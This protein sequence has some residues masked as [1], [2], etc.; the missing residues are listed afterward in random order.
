M[1]L[2]HAT[3]THTNIC[4][5][6][7]NCA[8]FVETKWNIGFA[9]SRSA[10]KWDKLYA[11]FILAERE[12]NNKK[13]SRLIPGQAKSKYVFIIYAHTHEVSEPPKIQWQPCA[14]SKFVDLLAA[15][16]FYSYL[17]L[18]LSLSADSCQ[19]VWCLFVWINSFRAGRRIGCFIWKQK[20]IN[21]QNAII[22]SALANLFHL[23]HRRQCVSSCRLHGHRSWENLSSG[24]K[25]TRK[26]GEKCC[27]HGMEA[28]RKEKRGSTLKKRN[29]RE[30]EKWEKPMCENQNGK[31]EKSNHSNSNTLCWLVHTPR[32]GMDRFW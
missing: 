7:A 15:W 25:S 10:T 18:S 9:G 31:G 30:K 16:H 1:S 26:M 29:A 11:C 28:K 2:T 22:K 12:Q 8:R 23:I 3:H 32:N 19:R 21:A 13:Q 6:N 4:R 14:F 27:T 24:Q 5:M 20:R 17:F